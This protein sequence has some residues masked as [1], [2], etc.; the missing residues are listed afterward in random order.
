MTRRPAL[1]GAVAVAVLLLG[2][3]ACGGESG[4]SAT[5]AETPAAKH[6]ALT[7]TAGKTAKSTLADLVVLPRGFVADPGN[8]TGAFTT[9]SY[10]STW[11]ADPALDRALLLNAGFVEGYRA[12]RLSPDKK[13]RFTVQLFK[14]ASSAKAQALQNGLWK[15]DAHDHPFAVPNALSDANVEYD[16][17]ADRSVATAEAS[18]TVGALVVELTVRETAA[19][20][21]TLTPD[22]GLV[23]TLAKDQRTRLTAA[24]N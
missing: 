8:P 15:Q 11:S 19:L 12:T 20:G 2:V 1:G 16:G 17:A 21:T 4:S 9:T 14:T 3:T 13:K 24:S 10:L 7:G 6:S 5:A 23:T 22:T 18:L